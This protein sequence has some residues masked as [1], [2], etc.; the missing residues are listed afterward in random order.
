M[1]H[2]YQRL[3]CGMIDRHAFVI[4]YEEVD[5]GGRLRGKKKRAQEWMEGRIGNR[6]WKEEE[7]EKM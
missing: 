2:I 1:W 4:L 5:V 7:Q 6:K 3:V